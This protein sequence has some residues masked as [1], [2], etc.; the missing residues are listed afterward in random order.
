MF[1]TNF[2]KGSK[3]VGDTLEKVIFYFI[4]MLFCTKFRDLRE[5]LLDRFAYNL[6]LRP[7]TGDAFNIF[8]RLVNLLNLIET[9]AVCT[10]ALKIR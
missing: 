10:S 1:F 3:R 7:N 6:D 9:K 8:S 2:T 5:A 4:F